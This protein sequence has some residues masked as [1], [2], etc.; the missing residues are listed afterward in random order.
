MATWRK[1]LWWL[2]GWSTALSGEESQP[3]DEENREDFDRGA[4][5]ARDYLEGR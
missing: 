2:V 3:I 5:A 1:S 4:A